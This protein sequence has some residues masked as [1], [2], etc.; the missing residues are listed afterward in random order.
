M[1]PIHF[2][3]ITH[4]LNRYGYRV[5]IPETPREDSINL[6]LQYVQ[7]DMCYPAIVVIG[8]MLQAI[9]SGKYDPDNTS[10]VLFQ[11]CGA[12]RATNYMN[13]LRRALRNAGYPQVPV[14]ACWGLEQDAFRLNLTGF[15]DVAKAVVYG[16]LLQNVTNRM[17]PYEL[18]KGDTDRLFK[19]WMGKVKEVNI[20]SYYFTLSTC[21]ITD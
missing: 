8:Q 10:I 7:N 9:K 1:A 6:G 4:V 15:K 2:A 13:L 20:D 21:V 19:K 14:F 5:V 18:H 12:C 16:D 3:L 11:T 17:R